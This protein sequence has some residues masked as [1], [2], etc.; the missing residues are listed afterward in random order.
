MR[1]T[2]AFAFRRRPRLAQCAGLLC[3]AAT[4]AFTFAVPAPALARYKAPREIDLDQA[5][6]EGQLK[7]PELSVVT[8]DSDVDR[9]SLLR[10]REN[11]RD[12]LA[13]DAGRRTSEKGRE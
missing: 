13:A 10:L 3:A 2:P 8:G 5:V 11:F 9:N 6:V 7:R 1:K 12:R 4:F